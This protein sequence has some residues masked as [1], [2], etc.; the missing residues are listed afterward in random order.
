MKED[1]MDRACCTH[2]EPEGKGPL[3]RPI[4][5]WEDNIKMYLREIGWGSMG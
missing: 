4:W 3:V 2:G 5:R 1:E